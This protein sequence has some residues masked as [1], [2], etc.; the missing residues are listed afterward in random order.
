M[1]IFD[2]IENVV[3]STLDYKDVLEA[4]SKFESFGYPRFNRDLDYR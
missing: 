3:I 2:N 4:I 1:I